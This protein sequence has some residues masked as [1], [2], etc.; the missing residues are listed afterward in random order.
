MCIR[1]SPPREAPPACRSARFFG[2]FGIC[3]NSGAE[4]TPPELQGSTLR[5]FLGPRSSGFERLER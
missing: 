3:A 1:D 4:S 2:R 5:P